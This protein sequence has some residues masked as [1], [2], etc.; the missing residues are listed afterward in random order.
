MR[1]LLGSSLSPWEPWCSSVLTGGMCNELSWIP[2][3][4]FLWIA[5][6]ILNSPSG[7]CG[8]KVKQH[9]KKKMKIH[10][11]LL[12]QRCS[13]A[14]IGGMCDDLSR[15]PGLQFRWSATDICRRQWTR[16]I[17]LKVLFGSCQ[18]LCHHCTL[19]W[20]GKPGSHTL[21][22]S[23]WG[24]LVASF[25][26]AETAPRSGGQVGGGDWQPRVT[27]CWMYKTKGADER[28]RRRSGHAHHFTSKGFAA[29]RLEF[30]P[31]GTW[32]K[33]WVTLIK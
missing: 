11:L 24:I 27:C 12:W 32:W 10:K 26:L 21:N 30:R 19:S 28:Q 20:W 8:W 13:Y 1:S 22:F 18:S 17:I 33:E 25:W 3:L 29:D 5:A 4:Q 31:A 14:Q 15:I 16:V 7:L 23:H 6:D 9:L 2:G